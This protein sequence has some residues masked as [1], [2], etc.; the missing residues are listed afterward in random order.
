MKHSCFLP[1]DTEENPWIFIFCDNL[2]Q[3]FCKKEEGLLMSALD[4]NQTNRI[5]RQNHHL[6]QFVASWGRRMDEMK[7]FFT[8]KPCPIS[9]S[10][11]E[12]IATVQMFD[13]HLPPT[14]GREIVLTRYTHPE[15]D[16]LLASTTRAI[17]TRTGSAKNPP[18]KNRR[19]SRNPVV[20]TFLSRCSKIADLRSSLPSSPRSRVIGKTNRSVCPRSR[21]SILLKRGL[22]PPLGRPQSPRPMRNRRHRS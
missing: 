10:V 17:T 2:S 18:T 3:R 20:P 1:R 14:V 7:T 12:K 5:N 4:P 8:E 9:R 19:K 13:F 6:R 21:K 15:K 16:V 22:Y 11:L